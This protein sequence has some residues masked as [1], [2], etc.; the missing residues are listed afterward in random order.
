MSKRNQK[1]DEA[2]IGGKI[3]TKKKKCNLKYS[4]ATCTYLGDKVSIIAHHDL[5]LL[6][7]EYPMV[8]HEC[9]KWKSNAHHENKDVEKNHAEILGCTEFGT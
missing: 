4:I 2:M 8:R 6:T 7:Y 5:S 9:Y 3:E 1:L